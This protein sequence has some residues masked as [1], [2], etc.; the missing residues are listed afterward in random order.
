ML[1]KNSNWPEAKVLYKVLQSTV[2][3]VAA[4]EDLNQLFALHAS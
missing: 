1:Y 2:A 3:V 4:V